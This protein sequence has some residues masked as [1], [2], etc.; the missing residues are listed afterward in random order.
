MAGEFTPSKRGS[1]HS[2]KHG[3]VG[4]AAHFTHSKGFIQRYGEGSLFTLG[5]TSVLTPFSGWAL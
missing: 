1:A 2:G 3:V 5:D 4:I